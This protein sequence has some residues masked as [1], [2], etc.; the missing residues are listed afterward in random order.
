MLGAMVPPPSQRLDGLLE[1][2]RPVWDVIACRVAQSSPPRWCEQRGWS[3]YLLSLTDEDLASGERHGLEN[4]LPLL[5]EPPPSLRQL[6]RD[7][8]RL[9]EPF[10]T[11]ELA[12]PAEPTAHVPLRKRAQVAAVLEACRAEFTS[13][14]RVVEV[15]AG[16]GHATRALAGQLS[17]PV[18][19]IDRD[20]VLVERARQLVDGDGVSFSVA[21][22]ETD[23]ELCAGDLVVGLHACGGLGEAL[24]RQAAQAGAHVLLVSCCLQKIAT[25]PRQPLS[26]AG[27]R[28]GLILQKSALGLTNLASF[29][30]IGH[31]DAVMRGR[32]ARHALRLLLAARGRPVPPGEEARGIHRRKFLRGLEAVAGPA[33][34][35]RGLAPPTDREFSRFTELAR[36]EHQRMRRLSL[37]RAMLGRVVELAVVFDRATFLEERGYAVRVEALFPRSV[38]PRNVAVL[39]TA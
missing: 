39:A 8:A 17:L 34:A 23:L 21:D 3:D 2:L 15:G 10:R 24:L 29:S 11:A 20:P 18:F 28:L 30:E 6:C 16:C 4:A 26:A 5:P 32:Q 27:Q 38:S 19:G 12:P 37:P 1:V 36:V 31:A 13:A 14:R 9:A 7:V 35:V 33:L 25:D 22:G